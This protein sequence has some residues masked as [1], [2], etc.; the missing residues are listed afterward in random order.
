MKNDEKV[1]TYNEEFKKKI[2]SIVLIVLFK[3]IHTLFSP[4]YP[5]FKSLGAV[6]DSVVSITLLFDVVNIIFRWIYTNSKNLT[7]SLIKLLVILSIFLFL[8]MNFIFKSDVIIEYFKFIYVSYIILLITFVTFHILFLLFKWK[9]IKKPTTPLIIFIIVLFSF[10]FLIRFF[11]NLIISSI[12]LILLIIIIY[13]ALQKIF[14]NNFSDKDRDFSIT[15]CTL[16]TNM[17]TT[18]SICCIC[19]FRNANNI[20]SNV[21]L[22]AGLCSIV[23]DVCDYLAEYVV[24]GNL[25]ENFKIFSKKIKEFILN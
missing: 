20:E 19:Y 4:F 17:L 9:N 11:Q 16:V 7:S 22:I 14:R 5:D 3:I 2:T 18:W 21:I 23:K 1:K 25:Y 8:I 12:F 24:D 10:Y 13:K 6:F 15:F